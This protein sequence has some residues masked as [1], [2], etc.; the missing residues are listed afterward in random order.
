MSKVKNRRVNYKTTKKQQAG[1]ILPFITGLCVG[2]FIA[3]VIYLRLPQQAD[4][5]PESVATAEPSVSV[6]EE[7]GSANK[8]KFDFY[9]ILPEREV[10]VPEWEPPELK[11]DSNSPDSSK[12]TIGAYVFQVGSF[13]QYSDADSVKARLTILGFPVEIQRVIINGQKVWFRVRVGPYDDQDQLNS[14]R[15][16]LSQNNMD[17]ILLRIKDEPE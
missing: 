15:Q 12:S 7:E 14:V 3:F 8:P 2:L 6:T 4:E 17:Y 11:H 1:A 9:T 5:P 10:K 13:Q 16:R